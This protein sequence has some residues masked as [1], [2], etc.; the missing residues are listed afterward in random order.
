MVKVTKAL[1]E[2][3]KLAEQAEVSAAAMRECLTD[4]LRNWWEKNYPDDIDLGS[5]IMRYTGDPE[6]IRL[7]KATRAA[8]ATDAGAKMLARVKR[9]E[10][11]V[12]DVRTGRGCAR[13]RDIIYKQADD[14]C[15]HCYT[16]QIC[17]ALAT[18]DAG[19]VTL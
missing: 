19:E 10:A 14:L 1:E 17:R 7:R 13:S 9:L 12:A 11:F 6:P 16:T 2:A 3:V 15:R 4:T 8:L 5:R 18:L